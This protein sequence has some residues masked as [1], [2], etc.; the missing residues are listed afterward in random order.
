VR[1]VCLREIILF[2]CTSTSVGTRESFEEH[3]HTSFVTRLQGINNTAIQTLS[4][5]MGKKDIHTS[6]RLYGS[7]STW[8][9]DQY[10]SRALV[11]ALC[12]LKSSNDRPAYFFVVVV[13]FPAARNIPRLIFD[14]P[15][16]PDS[17]TKQ[18]PLLHPDSD[19]AL[20][21]HPT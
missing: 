11:L 12:L 21:L 7:R 13:V 18:T 4:F 6:E 14:P 9:I 2:V 20:S 1:L 3:S 10:N 16:R 17:Q 15:A 19:P 5:C 8:Q